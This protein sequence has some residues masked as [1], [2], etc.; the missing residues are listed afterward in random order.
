[1]HVSMLCQMGVYMRGQGDV[2]QVAKWKDCAG[3]NEDASVLEP[4]Y[5]YAVL[6]SISGEVYYNI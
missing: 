6:F 2:V 4:V 1:M 5:S 3:S